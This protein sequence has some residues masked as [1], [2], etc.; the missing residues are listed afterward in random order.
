MTPNGRPSTLPAGTARDDMSS[1]L[2]KLVKRPIRLLAPT[3]S[4]ATSARVG[5]Q[6]VVGVSNAAQPSSSACPSAPSSLEPLQVVEVVDGSRHRRRA[7]RSPRRSGQDRCRSGRRA[8]R[9]ARRPPRCAR[10]RTP[11]RT[12]ARRPRSSGVMSTAT[13]STPR[14]HEPLDDQRRTP[15]PSRRPALPGCALPAP[16]CAAGD[17]GVPAG[18]PR[19]P[20]GIARRPGPL[21]SSTVRT[22]EPQ[23]AGEHRHAVVGSGRPARRRSSGRGPWSA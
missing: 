12:A 15:R 10:P 6:V 9:C 8:S 4:A 17:A 2:A 19:A 3:G 18:D 5:C 14:V 1:R 21:S 7:G 13:T 23:L 20:A 11:R 16:R 22:R